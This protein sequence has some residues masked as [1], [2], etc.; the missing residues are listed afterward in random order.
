MTVPDS[1]TTLI[2]DRPPGHGR[3]YQR[4]VLLALAAAGVIFY[5]L[6]ERFWREPRL[7]WPGALVR[8]RDLG[9]VLLAAALCWP[10]AI[11]QPLTAFLERIRHPSP[12]RRRL[13]TLWL[14]AAATGF[15]A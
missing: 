1:P 5:L 3:T 12:R 10:K 6:G 14:G 15:F 7:V 2:E 13:V 11:R 8:G 9:V 4:W